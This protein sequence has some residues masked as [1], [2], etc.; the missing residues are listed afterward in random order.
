MQ[1]NLVM[2]NWKLN[3]NKNEIHTETKYDN[4]IFCSSII[5]ENIIGTQFHPE[6]SG[7]AGLVIFKILK[8]IL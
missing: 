2:G 8:E 6:K 3:G 5:K 1:K 4:L 7:E